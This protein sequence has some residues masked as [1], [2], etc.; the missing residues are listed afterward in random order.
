M[1][2]M[3]W[4][5]FYREAQ[6]SICRSCTYGVTTPWCGNGTCSHSWLRF[7]SSRGEIL[8][9][10]ASTYGKGNS[11]VAELLFEESDDQA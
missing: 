6:A 10:N 3:S 4:D 9:C 5:D 2:D 1:K 7:R 8:K 11:Q